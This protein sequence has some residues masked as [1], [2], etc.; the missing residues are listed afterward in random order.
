[1]EAR[2][3]RRCAVTTTQ[4]PAHAA[5]LCLRG[6]NIF[7]GYLHDPVNTEKTIDKDGWMHS[8]ELVAPPHE[9]GWTVSAHTCR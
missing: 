6:S 1:M 5:R 2:D 8:G 9:V 4:D 3:S 7:V